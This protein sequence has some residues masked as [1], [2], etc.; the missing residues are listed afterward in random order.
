MTLRSLV[1]ATAAFALMGLGAASAQA[2]GAN[3]SDA[4]AKAVAEKVIM[5]CE[6]DIARLCPN[7]PPG[8]GQVMQCL[9]AQRTQV[10]FHCKRAL[11]QAKQAKNAADAAAAQQG[12]H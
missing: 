6:A 5:A 1:G 3:M 9:K 12:P 2:P 4:E 8:G 10:S 7:V 11:F